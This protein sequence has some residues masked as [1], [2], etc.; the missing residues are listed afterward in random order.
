VY[1]QCHSRHAV[2][3]SPPSLHPSYQASSVLR[4]D[5]TSTPPFALLASSA[6]SDILPA[7]E[8][9]G[10]PWLPPRHDAKREPASDPG[11]PRDACLFR[12]AGCCL[13]RCRA[14]GHNP[15]VTT[16][17]GSIPSRAGGRPAPLVLASFP[18]YASTRPLPSGLQAWIRG[19]WL[20]A[21]PAGL[22]PL[23]VATLPG[24][25]LHLVVLRR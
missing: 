23:V 18:D 4:S 25:F 19:R 7:E 17:R 14:L 22:H 13:Q 10:S 15:T 6:R 16:F 5:P 12:D 1:G 11:R 24:R 20:A 21:T 3:A 8:Q 9:R 2:M